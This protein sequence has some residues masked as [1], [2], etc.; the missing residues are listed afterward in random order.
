VGRG[1]ARW[2]NV[3]RDMVIAKDGF[4]WLAEAK[5]VRKGNATNAV[6]EAI[7]QLATY[8][9]CLY[10]I[11]AQP[12][13]LALSSEAIG[14]LPLRILEQEGL[15]L[16]EVWG[17]E[18]VCRRRRQ[19]RSGTAGVP[20]RSGEQRGQIDERSPLPCRSLKGPGVP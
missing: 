8:S 14:D 3:A 13:R 1:S 20:F 11:E 16:P 17:L 6:R 15:V 12:R 4:H 18:G 19:S 7:G 9:F 5:F 2:S 10:P